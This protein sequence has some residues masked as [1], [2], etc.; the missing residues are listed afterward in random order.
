MYLFKNS[1]YLLLLHL[2]DYY[3]LYRR[4]TKSV[5]SDISSRFDLIQIDALQSTAPDL[6]DDQF[7]RW[8]RQS[9]QTTIINECPIL[10]N[11]SQRAI[12]QAFLQNRR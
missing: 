5:C 2:I 1:I 4:I 3:I 8:K 12:L 9:S 11:V 7:L 10:L 6:A